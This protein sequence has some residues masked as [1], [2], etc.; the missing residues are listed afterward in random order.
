MC[1]RTQSPRTDTVHETCLI[2][3][4]Q[5]AH[6]RRSRNNS[7]VSMKSTARSRKLSNDNSHPVQHLFCVAYLVAPRIIPVAGECERQQLKHVFLTSHPPFL[8]PQFVPKFQAQAKKSIKE[9]KNALDDMPKVLA[10]SKEQWEAFRFVISAIREELNDRVRSISDGS[11]TG[12]DG[13]SMSI[14]PHVTG[15]YKDYATGIREVCQC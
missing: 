15:M 3:D 5:W 6:D 11:I 7:W 8:P 12:E 2:G 14:T 4:H 1:V 13:A 10:N 9:L